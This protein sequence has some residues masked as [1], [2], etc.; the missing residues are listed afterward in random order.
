MGSVTWEGDP[1]VVIQDVAWSA[2]ATSDTDATQDRWTD[3][4]VHRLARSGAFIV[5]VA[6]RTV[7]EGETERHSIFYCPTPE[8]LIKALLR[9]SRGG[10]KHMPSYARQVLEQA[11][12]KLPEVRVALAAWDSASQWAR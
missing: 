6:G 9:P 1:S 12:A 11:A 8:D 7:V 10:G 3:I 4:T 5:F 2:V